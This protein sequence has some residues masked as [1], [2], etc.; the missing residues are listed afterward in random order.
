LFY[1]LIFD[2]RNARARRLILWDPDGG[3]T[4]EFNKIAPELEMD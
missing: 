1:F 2:K 3:D 4:E